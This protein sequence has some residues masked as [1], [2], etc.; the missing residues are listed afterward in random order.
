MNPTNV[1]LLTTNFVAD[2]QKCSCHWLAPA[3]LPPL[4]FTSEVARMC[5][6]PAREIVDPPDIVNLWK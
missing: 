1:E 5:T 2:D 6:G 4:T 3:M